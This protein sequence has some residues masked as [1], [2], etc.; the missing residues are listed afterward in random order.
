MSGIPD[1]VRAKLA[2]LRAEFEHVAIRK[3]PGA[4]SRL[5]I[6]TRILLLLAAGIDAA[7]DHDLST[8]ALRDWREFT[9]PERQAI[10]SCVRG[11][12]DDLNRLR[13]FLS[14]N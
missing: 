4:W 1:G 9:P 10:A 11:L 3:A 6:Q 7:G 2:T 5:G 13:D 8:L 12:R 14:F